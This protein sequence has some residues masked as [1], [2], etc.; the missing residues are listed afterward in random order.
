[1]AQVEDISYIGKGLAYPI[2]IDTE[3]RASVSVGVDRIEQSLRKIIYTPKGTRY[4][5]KAY[6]SRIKQVIYDPNDAIASQMS[7]RFAFEAISENEPRVEF[8]DCSVQQTDSTINLGIKVRILESN[9]IRTFVF[10]FYKNQ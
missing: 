5:N 10:P 6:G 4:R 1:M 9:E 2:D 7:K 8:I 3:G